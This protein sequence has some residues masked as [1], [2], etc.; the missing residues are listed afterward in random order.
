M[1]SVGAWRALA[2]LSYVYGSLVPFVCAWVCWLRCRRP[3]RR[4]SSSLPNCVVRWV[5]HRSRPNLNDSHPPL[6][7]MLPRGPVRR[8]AAAPFGH[9]ATSSRSACCALPDCVQEP[10]NNSRLWMSAFPRLEVSPFWRRAVDRYED[11]RRQKGETSNGQNVRT[12]RRSV[13]R[14]PSSTR[15]SQLEEDGTD[16]AADRGLSV[17]LVAGVFRNALVVL[18]AGTQTVRHTAPSREPRHLPLNSS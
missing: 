13:G 4:P 3:C 5:F 11:G 18:W 15:G 9:R 12:T 8:L 6:W 16:G 7:R 2:A 1:R 10:K 14:S 17:R